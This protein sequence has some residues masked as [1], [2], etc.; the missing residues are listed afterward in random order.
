MRQSAIALIA[1]QTFSS[2]EAER[3]F[4]NHIHPGVECRPIEIAGENEAGF[5]AAK[6]TLQLIKSCHDDGR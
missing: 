2:R 1:F 4:V 3:A 5:E 6:A